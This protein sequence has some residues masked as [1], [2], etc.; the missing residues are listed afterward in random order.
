MNVLMCSKNWL[1]FKEISEEELTIERNLL[2]HI[3]EIG[4]DGDVL[5]DQV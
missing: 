4:V 2:T 5:E 3:Q 1:G